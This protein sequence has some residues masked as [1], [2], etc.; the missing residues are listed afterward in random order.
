MDEKECRTNQ[1]NICN[2]DIGGG[3]TLQILEDLR[4][5]DD[6]VEERVGRFIWPTAVPMMT[7]LRREMPPLSSSTI[8]VELGAGCGVLSMGLA[9]TCHFH[10]VVI[11]DH[12]VMWLERNLALNS[13]LFGV[14]LII[15]RLDWGNAAEIEAVRAIVDE[16]C[17]SI[18]FPNLLI[19]A[20]DVLYNHKSHQY[21]AS[22]LHRMSSI[23]NIPT[24]IMIGFLSD[25]DNDEASFLLNARQLFGDVFPESKSGFVER[26]GKS[27]TKEMEMHVIDFVVR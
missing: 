11:T 23:A 9:A 5:E 16:A 6:D 12:D 20:S 24:R 8:V 27:K 4:D 22:T 15:R 17:H 7:H 3:I 13:M 21:L 2:L 18:D 1:E 10:K 19:I 26:K 14:E 25:R